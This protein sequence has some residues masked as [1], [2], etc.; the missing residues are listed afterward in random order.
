MLPVQ[1]VKFVARRLQLGY[2]P[3]RFPNPLIITRSQIFIGVLRDFL[4]P[5][6]GRPIGQNS[7]RFRS[8]CNR[9]GSGRVSRHAKGQSVRLQDDDTQS[10]SL[11]QGEAFTP[12]AFLAISAMGYPARRQPDLLETPAFSPRA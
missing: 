11:S 2:K 5:Q 12:A 8:F 9:P 6:R 1:C 4:A 10:N 7:N 3:S